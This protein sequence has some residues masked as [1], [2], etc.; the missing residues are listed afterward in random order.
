M[1]SPKGFSPSLRG[2]PL[3]MV[4]KILRILVDSS[5]KNASKILN[6]F[7]LFPKVLAFLAH[8]DW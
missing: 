6:D 1:F 2:T 4:F 7:N 5:E 3:W 8:D